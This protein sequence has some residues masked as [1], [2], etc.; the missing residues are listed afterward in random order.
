MLF[1]GQR[2]KNNTKFVKE[3]GSYKCIGPFSGFPLLNL[4]LGTHRAPT[5]PPPACET[6]ISSPSARG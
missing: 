5:P 3:G 4:A 2:H 1:F 6:I